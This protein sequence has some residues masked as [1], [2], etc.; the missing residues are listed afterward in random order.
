MN[1]RQ[2]LFTT[3]YRELLDCEWKIIFDPVN[4]EAKIVNE[5]GKEIDGV[6][7]SLM[8][9]EIDDYG[10]RKHEEKSD[11]IRKQPLDEFTKKRL[12]IEDYV[13]IKDETDRIGRRV[14]E[15]YHDQNDIL[16]LDCFSVSKS[17][18]LVYQEFTAH[19]LVDE[20]EKILPTL[21]EFVRKKMR[22]KE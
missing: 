3:Q 12:E 6:P 2:R 20:V 14:F 18:N 16:T 1:T 11:K 15:V 22:S 17:N 21:N 5:N 9:G 10:K 8:L 19:L 13:L 7:L 4:F